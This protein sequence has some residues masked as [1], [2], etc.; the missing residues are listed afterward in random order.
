MGANLSVNRQKEVQ[1]IFTQ[2]LNQNI[3]NFVNER[4]LN[5]NSSQILKLGP[6]SKFKCGGDFKVIQT[7]NTSLGVL[8]NDTTQAVQEIANK[9]AADMTAQTKY[10]ADQSNQGIPILQL[11]TSVSE[12]EILQNIRSQ[13][14]N[15]LQTNVKNQLK[16]DANNTQIIIFDP[17]VE[18]TATGDCDLS[19]NAVQYMIAQS[20]VSNMASTLLTNDV[21][22][23]AKATADAEAKQKNELTLMG[24]LGGGI[25]GFIILI[26]IVFMIFN[27]KKKS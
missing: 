4:S 22:A 2:I 13:L 14:I 21:S 16:V 9:A 23:V 6:N 10:L 24:L 1:E 12:Q 20:T 5:T 18:I 27:K 11:N 3:Q 25:F 15:S 26:G 17:N 19:Q 7:S 8:L